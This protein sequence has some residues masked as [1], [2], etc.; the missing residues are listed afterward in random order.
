[1]EAGVFAK[2]AV[3][4]FWRPRPVTIDK[5]LRQDRR[6]KQLLVAQL[7]SVA[8]QPHLLVEMGNGLKVKRAKARFVVHR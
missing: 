3:N 5:Q 1:M 8:E 4:F 2:C 7:Q 6:N